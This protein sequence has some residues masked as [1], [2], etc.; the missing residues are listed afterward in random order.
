ML[1]LGRMRASLILA[2]MHPLRADRIYAAIKGVVDAGVNVPHS[3]EIFPEDERIRGEHIKK[4]TRQGYRGPIRGCQGER[5][6]G[7]AMDQKKER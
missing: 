3:S 7:E 2:C 5:Y 1:A 6:W 4:Y